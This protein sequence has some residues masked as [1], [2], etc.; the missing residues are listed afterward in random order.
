MFLFIG[1]L[2]F[3]IFVFLKK[4]GINKYELWLWKINEWM[5]RNKNIVKGVFLK[6]NNRWVVN[7]IYNNVF[8]VV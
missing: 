4:F 7:I 8:F 6:V 5:L 3:F 1:I 2:F